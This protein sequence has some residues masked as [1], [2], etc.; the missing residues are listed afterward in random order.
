MRRRPVERSRYRH[1]RSSVWWVQRAA[2]TVVVVVAAF[3]GLSPADAGRNPQVAGS[4]T[5]ITDVVPAS[6]PNATGIHDIEAGERMLVRG[7]TNLRPD[8]NVI[9]VQVISGPSASE[10]GY[11]DVRRWG[12]DG[13]WTGV[14]DVPTTVEPGTYVVRAD[15]GFRGDRRTIRIVAPREEPTT[16]RV[17]ATAVTTATG[18]ATTAA[19][20][21]TPTGPTGTTTGR[22]SETEVV[23]DPL[24]VVFVGFVLGMAAVFVLSRM[25]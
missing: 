13:V 9:T 25:F 1:G 14:L 10:F 5:F 8:R 3:S 22:Q 16:T 11:V 21:T 19:T 20:A 4:G 2:L 7:T 23:L 6:T 17:T 18:T 15:D 24:V 12:A